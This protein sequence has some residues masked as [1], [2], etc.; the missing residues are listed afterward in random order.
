MGAVLG[1]YLSSVE[2]VLYLQPQT[3]T[4]MVE[5]LHYR[6]SGNGELQ[7][8]SSTQI[9]PLGQPLRGYYDPSKSIHCVVGTNGIIA[10]SK[11][12]GTVRPDCQI[13]ANLITSTCV[14]LSPDLTVHWLNNDTLFHSF[15]IEEVLN[16]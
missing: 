13:L 16:N 10:S 5:V 12:P 4:S 15:R 14:G 1:C 7:F 3:N 8:E 11:G 9:R 2:V 6:F